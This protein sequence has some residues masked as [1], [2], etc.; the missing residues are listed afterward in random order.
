MG[1]TGQYVTG[2]W[3]GNDD[4]SPTARVTGANIPAMA[5][6]EFMMFAHVTYNIPKV[7]G[8]PVHPA[9]MAE[10]QRVAAL[11]QV[12]ATLG[13]ISPAFQRISPKT[14]KAL[15]ALSKLLKDSAQ[16][17]LSQDNQPQ[18]QTTPPSEPTSQGTP[19]GADNPDQRA[20]LRQ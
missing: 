15:Q 18:R 7:P 20:S 3:F 1:F 14:R 10:Q 16:A 13:R 9:Q 11:R 17:P 5:W 4:Y 19:D 12:D 6:K 2:T 8:V